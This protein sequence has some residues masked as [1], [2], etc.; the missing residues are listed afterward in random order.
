MNL[1]VI[2]KKPDLGEHENELDLLG[3]SIGHLWQVNFAMSVMG[4]D[5]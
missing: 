2:A 5:I 3:N 1:R 4:L